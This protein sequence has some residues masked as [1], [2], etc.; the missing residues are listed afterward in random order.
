MFIKKILSAFWSRFV[1]VWLKVF[2]SVEKFQNNSCEKGFQQKIRENEVF[3]F[4]YCV[5]FEA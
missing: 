1:R 5:K 2:E 4:H 3:D